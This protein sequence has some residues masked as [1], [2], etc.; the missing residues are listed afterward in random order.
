MEDSMEID[1]PSIRSRSK[2]VVGGSPVPIES[3]P[4][5]VSLR[6][7]FDGKHLCGGSILSPF[8]ILTAAHCLKR[9][10]A[11]ATTVQVGSSLVQPSNPQRFEVVEAILHE[12][13][14]EVSEISHDLKNDIALLRLKL[15]IQIGSTDSNVTSLVALFERNE[16]VPDD[17]VATVIGWGAV[18]E[19][20]E[21]DYRPEWVI[22]EMPNGT[23]KRE[24][25]FPERLMSV[26]IRT[27]S[28]EKCSHGY[29]EAIESD[30]LCAYLPGKD[31]CDGDS[32]GPLM[33]GRKQAGIVSGGEDCAERNSP[34]IYTSVAYFREWID[35]NVQVLLE[36]VAV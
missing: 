26:E 14:S 17:S 2:R 1:A 20:G 22:K 12:N 10:R 36:R 3:F 28:S 32:G 27:V 35:K 23:W 21:N 11:N 15:P 24:S 29:E 6:A 4:F 34:G 13:F 8:I 19:P 9:F 18:E 16:T 7:P 25:L 31:S 30:R 33:I 5:V